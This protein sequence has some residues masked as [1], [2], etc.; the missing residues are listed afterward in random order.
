MRT[1][2]GQYDS[3]LYKASSS[4]RG[5]HVQS[6]LTKDDGQT[7]QAPFPR[8]DVELFMDTGFTGQ[9]I[10]MPFEYAEKLKLI[11]TPQGDWK[12]SELQLFD[13]RCVSVLACHPVHVFIPLFDN[14]HQFV[15]NKD[16][17]L[18][19]SCSLPGPVVQGVA[20]AEQFLRDAGDP[21]ECAS[22]VQPLP[23]T[24]FENALPGL[25]SGTN[26]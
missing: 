22:S 6:T 21:N 10:L 24:S 18:N 13:G 9:G 2:P 26:V 11:P 19:V 15:T 16:T 7:S 25:F 23:R 12:T 3:A 1:R 14:E 17:W 8:L 5:W 4:R 20:L